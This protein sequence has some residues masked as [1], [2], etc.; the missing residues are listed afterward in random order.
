MVASGN[1]GYDN[2][3]QTTRYHV[4]FCVP[5]PSVVSRRPTRHNLLTLVYKLS[6]IYLQ[7]QL[8]SLENNSCWRSQE[9]RSQRR[10]EAYMLGKLCRW[11]GLDGGGEVCWCVCVGEGGGY[12]FPLIYVES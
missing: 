11:V 6:R 5:G 2:L 3:A 1:H 10:S 8:K 7:N 4:L 9:V 12:T